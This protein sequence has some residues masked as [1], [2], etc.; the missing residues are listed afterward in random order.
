[1]DIAIG[2]LTIFLEVSVST[3]DAGDFRDMAS[4]SRIVE[5]EVP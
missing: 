2:N 4:I 1:M 5:H 3:I